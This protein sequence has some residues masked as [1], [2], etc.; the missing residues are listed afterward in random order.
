MEYV[1]ESFILNRDLSLA[2]VDKRIT[3]AMRR[4]LENLNIKILD[5]IECN[6]TYNAIKFHPDIY[7]CKL[8]YNN[9][10]VAPN[11][12]DYYN[13][14]LSQYGFNVIKG[15]SVI[16]YK[17]PNNTQYN[18]CILGKYA[19]HN[20]DYTDKRILDYLDNN[21]FIKINLKQGY[22]KCSICVVDEKSII[23]SDEGVYNT[24]KNHN[25]DC[26]LIKKGHIDLFELNYGFIGGCSGLISNDKLAF[27]GDITKHPDYDKI[28]TFLNSKNKNI[29]CL[30]KEK[31]LDLGSII[32]LMVK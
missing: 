3:P 4:S 1:K 24:V 2:L 26:L 14:T 32:P 7:I 10:I 12:Y 27:C 5:T 21:N 11:V 13:K 25:I 19:I 23:T 31:L 29:I 17:Y 22:S 15:S 8:D 9:I 20:F 16:K 18:I 28:L 6:D 30:S